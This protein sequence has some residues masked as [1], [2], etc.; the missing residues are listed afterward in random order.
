MNLSEFKELSESI[1]S[2][3]V[4][5]GIIIGGI[6]A[7]YRFLKLKEIDKA[8]SELLQL[9]QQI[10]EK[11]TIKLDVNI[12]K[13]DNNEGCI[14]IVSIKIINI[15]NRTEILDIK[16]SHAKVLK[17][18]SNGDQ[19]GNPIEGKLTGVNSFINSASISPNEEKIFPIIFKLN[20]GNY[21]FEFFVDGSTNETNRHI[22]G[23]KKLGL[24]LENNSAKWGVTKY[25]CIK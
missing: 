13:L 22:D 15:G 3:T 8:K 18:D 25:F 16:K 5:I 7:I 1:Q 19:I 12:E 17:I 11:A 6:W 10:E 14:T 9:K 20:S 21:F 4:S 24:F 23:V 2:L